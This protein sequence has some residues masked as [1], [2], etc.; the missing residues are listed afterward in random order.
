MR[1]H[2]AV[3]LVLWAALDA[4]VA[5]G[6]D[7]PP[8]TISGAAAAASEGTITITGTGFGPRP[9]VTLNLVP[10][11]VRAALATEILA[12][13][14]IAIMPPGTYLLTVSR[15]PERT[16]SASIDVALGGAPTASTAMAGRGRLAGAP[17]GSAAP[18]AAPF[19]RPD[20]VAARVGDRTFT[21][22]EVDREWQRLDPASYVGVGRRMHEMRSRIVDQLVAD[23]LLAREAAARKMSIDALLDEEL[24]KRIVPLPDSS[25]LA[26]YQQLGDDTRGASLDQ[27]RPALRAWL[28]RFTEPELARMNYIEELMRVSTRAEVLLAAP[29]IAVRAAATDA[30][31]GGSA[32]PVEIVAFGDLRSG[33]YAQ[34][35]R[36]FGQMRDTFGDRVRLVF[37]HLPSEDSES[38]GASEAAVCA[39]AQGKFWA[40]HD[41]VLAEAGFLG[42]TRIGAV[43]EQAGLDAPRFEACRNGAD[44][45]RAVLAA[46]EEARGYD[47][48]TA[49]SFLVNGR[50]APAPPPFLPP[51]EFFTRLIEEELIS[52]K[53]R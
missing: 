44:V 20:D 24:P 27:M 1:Q 8:L 45:R 19:A 28:A 10:L 7:R 3:A 16:D 6:Q 34:F 2:I 42:P 52:Q 37:K 22:A 30:A 36:A 47:I 39:N 50:L 26:L 9:F 51:F 32:A 31:L 17:V 53:G 25:V 49:P 18:P 12:A 33:R 13:A 35:A 5:A 4:A 41:A 21:V 43:A 15:G 46:V 40:F 14:P 11:T 29:R 23:E 38:L 48:H